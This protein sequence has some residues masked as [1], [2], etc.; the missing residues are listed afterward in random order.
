[1]LQLVVLIELRNTTG[2]ACGRP[3]ISTMRWGKQT[4]GRTMIAAKKAI[5][6]RYNAPYVAT[7]FLRCARC[8][9]EK[10]GGRIWR[11]ARMSVTA[12]QT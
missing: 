2:T 11:R 5:T 10:I 12:C 6:K 3:H 8:L 9:N 7:I 4:Q 1:M